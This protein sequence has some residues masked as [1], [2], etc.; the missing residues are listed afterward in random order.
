[1][2]EYIVFIL[3]YRLP[4]PHSAAEFDGLFIQLQKRV[5][6][7]RSV[8]CSALTEME[9]MK[10]QYRRQQTAVEEGELWDN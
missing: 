9:R 8:L 5:I 6:K 10:K 2:G 7:L 3:T 4:K 1:M